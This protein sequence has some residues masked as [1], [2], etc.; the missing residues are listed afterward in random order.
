MK[1]GITPNEIIEEEIQNL[2]SVYNYLR[3]FLVLRF[4]YVDIKAYPGYGMPNGNL[5]ITQSLAKELDKDFLS[6]EYLKKYVE[7]YLNLIHSARGSH[8]PTY[9]T[10]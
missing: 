1:D 7:G 9:G 2:S 5:R 4:A 6:R 10:I 3:F 8:S